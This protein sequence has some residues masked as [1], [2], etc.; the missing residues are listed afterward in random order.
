MVLNCKIIRLWMIQ[1]I[2]SPYSQ[3]N[4][5]KANENL[6]AY[7]GFGIR[8]PQRMN[9]PLS[10]LVT[11]KT[12]FK[13]LTVLLYKLFSKKFQTLI[14]CLRLR[15]KAALAW[16]VEL[17]EKF[18]ARSFK[19]FFRGLYFR[20]LKCCPEL[21]VDVNGIKWIKHKASSYQGLKIFNVT[22]NFYL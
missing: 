8:W 10:S 22:I 18:R 16:Q 13:T 21:R 1:T 3:K 20:N 5:S 17:K 11:R 9:P 19:N 2:L 4:N 7:G 12:T 15:F 14:F 6:R